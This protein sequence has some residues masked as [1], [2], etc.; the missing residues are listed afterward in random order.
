[1]S[2]HHS[3]LT[4]NDIVNPQR[5]PDGLGP[6]TKPAAQAV[7]PNGCGTANVT[8]PQFNFG[9]CCDAHDMCYSAC[10]ATFDSCNDAFEQC[11]YDRCAA[12]YMDEWDFFHLA[13]C[14]AG[15]FFYASVVMIGGVE[16]FMSATR[17]QCDCV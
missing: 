8:V 16:A 10:G 15:A 14:K 4:R 2:P 13:A 11:M 7:V 9:G 17:D 3:L 12:D 6:I 5:C 1:M